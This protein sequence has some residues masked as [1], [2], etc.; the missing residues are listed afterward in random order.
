MIRK[1]KYPEIKFKRSVIRPH[2]L[3]RPLFTE[4]GN[5]CNI[6][7]CIFGSIH[8]NEMVPNSLG[9]VIVSVWNELAVFYN[10]VEIDKFVVMPNHFHGIIVL[11]GPFVGEG[12]R[13]FPRNGTSTKIF[14]NPPRGRIILMVIFWYSIK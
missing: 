10:G 7:K 5:T 12:P 8:N 14:D 2:L 4:T 13:A 11:K 1:G 9:E 3:R 6:K